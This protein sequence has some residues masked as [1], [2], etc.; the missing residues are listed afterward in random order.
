[1]L[2]TTWPAGEWALVPVGAWQSHSTVL[3]FVQFL[4]GSVCVCV[5]VLF[6]LPL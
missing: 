5:V 2:G 6:S 1:V 4:C 3:M